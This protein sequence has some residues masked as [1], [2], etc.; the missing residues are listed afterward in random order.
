MG[1]W[2]EGVEFAAIESFQTDHPADHPAHGVRRRGP[3]AGRTGEA[4]AADDDARPA[5]GDGA[6]PAP[7]PRPAQPRRPLQGDAR[8]IPTLVD[9]LVDD[10]LADPAARRADRHPRDDA[11][12][13]PRRGRTPIEHSDVADELLTLLVAGHETTASA[14]SWSVE[15]LRRHPAIL[16]RLEDEA[17]PD[18]NALRLATAEEVSG[19]AR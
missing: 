3:R 4:A 16:R 17:T 5:P 2:P 11:A 14:L 19:C 7:R 12:R 8:R 10:H 1:S 13:L 6:D 18:E 9:K 15:R